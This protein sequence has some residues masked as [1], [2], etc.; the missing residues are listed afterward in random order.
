M[1]VDIVRVKPANMYNHHF[2]RSLYDRITVSNMH[3]FSQ[4]HIFIDLLLNLLNTK[5]FYFD[6]TLKPK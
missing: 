4:I 5:M 3:T 2:G 6:I 1:Y